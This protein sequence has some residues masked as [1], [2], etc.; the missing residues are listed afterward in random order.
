LAVNGLFRE[1]LPPEVLP[2]LAQYRA[3]LKAA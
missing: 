3:G 1:F 2:M